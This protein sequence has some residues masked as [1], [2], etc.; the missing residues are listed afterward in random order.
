MLIIF[1]IVFLHNIHLLLEKKKN[2]INAYIFT[3][4]ISQVS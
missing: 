1:E 2:I 4:I 3:F